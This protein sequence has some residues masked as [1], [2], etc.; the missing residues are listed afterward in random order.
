ALF[1]ESTVSA[2]PR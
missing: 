1:E 2:E